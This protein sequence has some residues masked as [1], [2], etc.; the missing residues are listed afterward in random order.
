MKVIDFDGKQ[1]IIHTSNNELENASSLHIKAREILQ[2]C[3]PHTTIAEEVIL[4]GCTPNRVPLR[5]D[6]L[7]Q[8]L[9][10]IVEVQG[11][12]H[13]E[14]CEHFHKTEL[15]FKI[16]QANDLYKKDWCKLNKIIHLELPYNRIDEWENIINELT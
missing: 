15:G 3:F 5:A 13:Y 10:L 12:Q 2:K 11:K 16:Y 1:H 6:F 14:Y 7:L 9:R 4:S 8:N